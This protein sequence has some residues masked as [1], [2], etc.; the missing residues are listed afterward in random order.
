MI[1]ESLLQHLP[2]FAILNQK[3]RDLASHVLSRLLAE[4]TV[5]EVLQEIKNLPEKDVDQMLEKMKACSRF[6]PAQYLYPLPPARNSREW[7]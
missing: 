5:K 2:E 3:R 7:N 1:L 4:E 6:L